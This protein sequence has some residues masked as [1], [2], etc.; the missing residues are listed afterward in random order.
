MN[1][2]PRVHEGFAFLERLWNWHYLGIPLRANNPTVVRMSLL[3]FIPER[4]AGVVFQQFFWEWLPHLNSS[5]LCWKDT[6]KV[7]WVI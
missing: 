2:I 1:R 5:N 6:P 7:K 3:I 4:N